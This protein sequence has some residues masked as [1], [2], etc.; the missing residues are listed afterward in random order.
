MGRP[1][2]AL[3]CPS[4]VVNDVG[5]PLGCAD[6][7]DDQA[8]GPLECPVGGVIAAPDGHWS[9]RRRPSPGFGRHSSAGRGI[10]PRVGEHSSARQGVYS[11]AEH[12]S[13]SSRS[14]GLAAKE[15]SPW[16]HAHHWLGEPRFRWEIGAPKKCR[17]LEQPPRR[18]SE[19]DGKGTHA[20]LPRP[21]GRGGIEARRDEDHHGCRAT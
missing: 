11:G 1:S 9:A 3:E 2:G 16:V 5:R 21:G 20:L 12:S 17:R 7:V 6:E 19:R 8:Q 13:V 18:G 14:W 10:H 15:R 4:K